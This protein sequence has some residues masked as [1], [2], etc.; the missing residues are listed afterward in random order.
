MAE[1]VIVYALCSLI[2]IIT[3]Y[4]VLTFVYQVRD[5]KKP[6]VKIRLNPV[7]SFELKKKRLADNQNILNNG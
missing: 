5:N 2:T 6:Y 1:F 3:V 4:W 7:E